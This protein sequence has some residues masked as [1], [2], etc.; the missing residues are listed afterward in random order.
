MPK[1]KRPP[2]DGYEEIGATLVQPVLEGFQTDAWALELAELLGYDA[3]DL[4]EWKRYYKADRKE[5]LRR[6]REKR[7]RRRGKIESSLER[8]KQLVENVDVRDRSGY[9]SP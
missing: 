4:H 2:P 8:A 6:Q 1:P 5:S 3:Q 9:D 7:A